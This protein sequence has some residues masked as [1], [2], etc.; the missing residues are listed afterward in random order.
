MGILAI[1]LGRK[2]K[3]S[4]YDVLLL[5]L[6]FAVAS[7]MA[8]SAC[9]GGEGAPSPVPTDPTQPPTTPT[10]PPNT[11]TPTETSPNPT[12]TPPAPTNL[13]TLPDCPAPTY[14]EC[15]DKGDRVCIDPS[16]HNAVEQIAHT[17]FGEG[18]A[19]GG[20][21][22]ANILQ[23]V[24]NR[25]YIYWEITHHANIN[26]RNTPWKQMSRN[27]FTDL[28]LFIL[29][30]P[31]GNGHAA[32]NAWEDPYPHSGLYWSRTVDA[33][34]IMLDDAG[35]E[36]QTINIKVGNYVPASAIRSNINV[37][38][39]AA[40]KTHQPDSYVHKDTIESNGKYCFAQYYDVEHWNPPDEVLDC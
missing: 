23:T 11:P 36:P 33:I 39:Y 19:F 13:P 12:Q 22:A 2:K 29:S 1:L 15:S 31:T 25:A 30:E 18:G 17:V 24:V 8:V 7:G 34:D 27:Q 40:S 37:K 14:Y 16:I 26:P 6:V 21:V 35:A 32:Y 20:W 10:N 38:W 5:V 28:I 9:G 3:K 4:K